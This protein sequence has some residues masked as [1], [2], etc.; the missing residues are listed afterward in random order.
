[1]HVHTAA[2]RM[3]HFMVVLAVSAKIDIS[4]VT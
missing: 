4:V 1:M 2:S 3:C